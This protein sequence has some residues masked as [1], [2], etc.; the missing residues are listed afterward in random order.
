MSLVNLPFSTLIVKKKKTHALNFPLYEFILIKF[1]W[2][3][4]FH[5]DDSESCKI[6]KQ[7]IPYQIH[8]QKFGYVQYC[9]SVSCITFLFKNPHKFLVGDEMAQFSLFLPSK[10]NYTNCQ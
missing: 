9:F 7:Q 2:L 10:Y 5:N 6:L 3:K 8:Y 4:D 1:F